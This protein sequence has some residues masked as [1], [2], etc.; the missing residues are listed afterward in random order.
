MSKQLMMYEKVVPLNSLQHRDLYLKAGKDFRF[1]QGLN[2]VPLT[3]VEF[4]SAASEYAIV[5]AGSK[6]DV[7]PAVIMGAQKDENLYVGDAGWKS[8]YIPAFVRQYPFVFS[9]SD[10]RKQ[11]VLCIDESFIGFNREGRGERLF[12]ADGEQ[13]QYLRTILAFMENYQ[14]HFRY[15]Q[16]FCKKL[17][18]L[19][20]LQPM[21]AT[22]NIKGGQTRTIT[23][24]MG[25]DRAKL[26]QLPDAALAQL[27]KNDWLEMIYLHLQSVRSFGISINRVL[28]PA[29]AGLEADDEAVVEESAVPETVN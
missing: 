24:F 6:E 8:S 14:T 16:L 12:D 22:V 5:F 2:S 27:H 21:N 28:S 26:K 7:M 3:A 4:S 17:V 25:V 18:E 20:L 29:A 9:Q 11:L 10:D 15:T 13:T 1:A 19:D 23:G